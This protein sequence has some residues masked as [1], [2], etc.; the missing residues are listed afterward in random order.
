MYLYCRSR[1]AEHV[2]LNSKHFIMIFFLGPPI[3]YS[4]VP[5]LEEP[6][7]LL[8]YSKI[9]FQA[10]TSKDADSDAVPT[11]A[12]GLDFYQTNRD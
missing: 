9:Y 10:H 7:Q 8:S 11:P 4:L 1:P 6:G 5:V 2:K 12:N 3:I